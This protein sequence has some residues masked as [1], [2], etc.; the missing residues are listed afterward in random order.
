MSQNQSSSL[1]RVLC[2]HDA[3]SNSAELSGKLHSLGEKLYQNH[4]IDLVFVDAPLIV[5]RKDDENDEGNNDSQEQK[6][7]RKILQQQAPPRA[8]WEEQ[9]RTPGEA[10]PAESGEEE[11]INPNASMDE[12]NDPPQSPHYVGL[13]ASLLLLKQLWTSSTFWG[14]MAFGQAAGVAAL[15]SL[16]PTEGAIEAMQPSFLIFVNGQSLLDEEELLTEHLHLPCLH[17]VDNPHISQEEPLPAIPRSNPTQRLVRQFGGTVVCDESLASLS[18]AKRTS[19]VFHNHVGSFLVHQKRKLRKSRKDAAVLALRHELQRTEA[20][21]AQLVAREIAQ[22][23]PDCLM[24]VITPK[25]VGGFSERRKGPAGGGAPCPSEF[26]LQRAKRSGAEETTAEGQTG[27]EASRE[28]PN[29]QSKSQEQE[30][31]ASS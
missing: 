19:A 10:M 14:I 22:D 6:V 13:D 18:K 24:A 30:T 3:G 9:P 20:D 11:N 27:R 31:E 4:G 1:L 7:P 25:N 2:L 29:Q 15:L 23:P 5:E 21:A 26:L 16:L 17:V 28:H 12:N 8:W